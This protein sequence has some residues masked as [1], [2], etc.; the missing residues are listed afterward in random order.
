LPGEAAWFIQFAGQYSS[1]FIFD[2]ASLSRTLPIPGML[3]R[4]RKR[5]MIILAIPGKVA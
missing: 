4:N 1:A 2:F 3:A 5:K